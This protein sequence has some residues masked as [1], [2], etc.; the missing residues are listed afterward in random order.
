MQSSRP[1]AQALEQVPEQQLQQQ[2]SCSN[3]R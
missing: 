1:Q 3:H 2:A